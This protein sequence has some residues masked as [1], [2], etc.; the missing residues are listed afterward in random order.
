MPDRAIKVLHIHRERVPVLKRK[1]VPMRPYHES[2]SVS[3]SLKE[4]LL[5]A[6]TVIFRP[7]SRPASTWSQ[8]FFMNCQSV[9]RPTR[10]PCNSMF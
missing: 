1:P 10:F 2:S 3:D 5:A 8:L 9:P 7:I 4:G 6:N